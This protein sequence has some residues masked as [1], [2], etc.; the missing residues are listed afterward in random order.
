M[1]PPAAQR[2]IDRLH[3]SGRERATIFKIVSFGLVGVVNTAVDLGMFSLGYYLFG[4]PIVAANM[5]SW[6]VAVTCSYLLNSKIT[7]S[8]DSQREHG[9]LSSV[10]RLFV[11]NHYRQRNSVEADETARDVVCARSRHGRGRG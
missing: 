10:L 2:L 3:D 5:F 9:N 6:S 4:L 11:L 7:F 1:V 8:I